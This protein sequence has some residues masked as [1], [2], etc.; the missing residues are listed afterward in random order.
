MDDLSPTHTTANG[1]HKV[2]ASK[3]LSKRRS[4]LYLDK[5]IRQSFKNRLDTDKDDKHLNYL[6]YDSK[7]VKFIEMYT[8]KILFLFKFITAENITFKTVKKTL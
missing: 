2:Q 3:V 8:W 6:R 1:Q 5:N 4:N 7:I